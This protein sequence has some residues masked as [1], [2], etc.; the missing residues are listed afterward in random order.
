MTDRDRLDARELGRTRRVSAG[1]IVGGCLLAGFA[2]GLVLLQGSV[3]NA[4][5]RGGSVPAPPAGAGPASSPSVV[6]GNRFFDQ[7]VGWINA[8]R[9]GIHRINS[10]YAS[11]ESVKLDISDNHQEGYLRL[12]FG[13]PD[14]FRQ[15]WRQTKALARGTPT[16]TKLLNGKRM[17]ILQ[18]DNSVRRMHG[19]PDGQRAI[20][21]LESDLNRLRDLAKFLTLQGLKGRGTTFEDM[22]PVKPTGPFAGN[23][24][25]VKRTLRGGAEMMFYFAYSADAQGRP[26]AV[27]YPGVVVVMGDAR[28]QEPTEAYVLKN[29]KNGPQFRY[30][31]QIEAYMLESW[32]T[33]A[34]WRRFLLA[35]PTDIRLNPVLDEAKTFLPPPARPK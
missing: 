29:W 1:R 26:E 3:E 17:W 14:K 6:R 34:Q 13:A 2:L 31:G 25:R 23:W 10:F 8:G 15:E 18:P 9:P 19:T 24:T 22:G 11:L 21:Q 27:T 30:P 20:P 33:G 5:G 28:R 16:T 32:K 7:A 12:W 4:F 35:Y